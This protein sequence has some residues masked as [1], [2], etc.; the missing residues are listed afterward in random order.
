MSYDY[1]L[2]WGCLAVPANQVRLTQEEAAAVQR[3]QGLGFSEGECLE[4]YLACVPAPSL[5][6]VLPFLGSV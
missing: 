4:A 6:H 5:L 3:L 2:H 1:L